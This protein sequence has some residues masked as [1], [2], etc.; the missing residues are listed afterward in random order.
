MRQRRAISDRPLSTI[1]II[2]IC[3]TMASRQTQRQVI[4]IFTIRIYTLLLLTTIP[5]IRRPRQ[6]LQDNRDYWEVQDRLQQSHRL[7]PRRP[8]G[9]HLKWMVRLLLLEVWMQII[10]AH[11]THIITTTRDS[12]RPCITITWISPATTIIRISTWSG[13]MPLILTLCRDRGEG[14]AEWSRGE[15]VVI[16]SFGKE[17]EK[18]WYF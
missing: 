16:L 8:V 7:V 5:T 18:V 17:E 14:E 3:T 2:W 11:T 12:T 4:T 10:W 9:L 15:I 13:R 6:V 1:T